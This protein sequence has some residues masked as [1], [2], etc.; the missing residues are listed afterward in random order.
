MRAMT[1]DETYV[2]MSTSSGYQTPAEWAD[3]CSLPLPQKQAV[4]RLHRNAIFTQ[5]PDKWAAFM[6]VLGTAATVLGDASGI[7]SAYAVFKAL[8]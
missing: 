2:A 1:E 3:F 8:V 6:G 4:A 5:G 7:G